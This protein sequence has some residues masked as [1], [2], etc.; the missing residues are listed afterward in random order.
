MYCYWG[1]LQITPHPL[2]P[3]STVLGRGDGPAPGTGS[4]R[5]AGGWLQNVLRPS[6]TKHRDATDT[7]ARA[8]TV[9][10]RRHHLYSP[11]PLSGA[12]PMAMRR[13]RTFPTQEHRAETASAALSALYRTRLQRRRATLRL[14]PLG[15]VVRGAR[16]KVG[17]HGGYVGAH[18]RRLPF[19]PWN[20]EIYG[21]LC[22]VDRL[23]LARVHAF[24][25]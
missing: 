13:H 7:S 19:L 4:G 10:E 11:L 1:G 22:S 18:A 21:I 2:S 17:K 8:I 16:E 9:A 6:T 20:H 5:H 23:E 12:L 24:H 15:L 3:V 14:E 25:R